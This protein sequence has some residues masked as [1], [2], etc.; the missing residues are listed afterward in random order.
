MLA[1]QPDQETE[2][3]PSQRAFIQLGWVEWDSERG[4]VPSQG[5]SAPE[6]DSPSLLRRL[7]KIASGQ[8]TTNPHNDE[9]YGQRRA[10]AIGQPQPGDSPGSRP[11]LHRDAGSEETPCHPSAGDVSRNRGASE[12]LSRNRAWCPRN[13]AYQNRARGSSPAQSKMRAL[14]HGEEC[15]HNDPAPQHHAEHRHQGLPDL[16]ARVQRS[17]CSTCIASRSLAAKQCL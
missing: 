9:A 11:G 5:N 14:E 12:P 1:L 10:E 16:Y 13:H 15:Q 2:Y 17:V 4:A 6:R 8:K 7:T 3:S